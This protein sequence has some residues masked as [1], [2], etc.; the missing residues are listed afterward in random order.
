MSS[1]ILIEIL[2]IMVL[3]AQ[4][5]CNYAGKRSEI[6]ISNK[7]FSNLM[8]TFIKHFQKNPREA[9]LLMRENIKLRMNFENMLKQRI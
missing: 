4:S 5:S 7:A 8:N 1:K 6:S 2:V 3:I 9:F